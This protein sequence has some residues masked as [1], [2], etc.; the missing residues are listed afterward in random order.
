MLFFWINLDPRS[1]QR[2]TIAKHISNKNLLANST[3]KNNSRSSANKNSGQTAVSRLK[4]SINNKLGAVSVGKLNPDLDVIVINNSGSSSGDCISENGKLL[5][6]QAKAKHASQ[7]AMNNSKTNKRCNSAIPNP[8]N[9]G[10]SKKGNKMVSQSLSN[11]RIALADNDNNNRKIAPKKAD[12]S[13]EKPSVP[14]QSTVSSFNYSLPPGISISAGT[15]TNL[16]IT[17]SSLNPV[18]PRMQNRNQSLNL[19]MKPMTVQ[20]FQKSDSQNQ[21]LGSTDS[22][23]KKR[24]SLNDCIDELQK[25][26]LKLLESPHAHTNGTSESINGNANMPLSNGRSKSAGG[27]SSSHRGAIVKDTATSARVRDPELNLGS[28]V[29]NSSDAVVAVSAVFLDPHSYQLS[30]NTRT[31][32]STKGLNK[33]GLKKA[34][35]QQSKRNLITAPVSGKK[36]SNHKLKIKPL[37]KVISSTIRNTRSTAANAKIRT[38]LS[39]KPKSGGI[40]PAD[41]N[42]A[43][44]RSRSRLLRK[45]N[46]FISPNNRKSESDCSSNCTSRSNSAIRIVSGNGPNGRLEK[47]RVNK[48]PSQAFINA[49]ADLYQYRRNVMLRIPKSGVGIFPSASNVNLFNLPESPSPDSIKGVL[50]PVQDKQKIQQLSPN[51]PHA[52]HNNH[53]SAFGSSSRSSSPML[54]AGSSGTSNKIPLGSMA[55]NAAK[56][57]A[58]VKPLSPASINGALQQMAMLRRQPKWS[59]GWRFGKNKMNIHTK[60]IKSSII[61]EP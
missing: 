9:H 23:S 45:R 43:C 50:S 40:N 60:L 2:T 41:P 28:T 55:A 25:K 26:R 37:E 16:S 21:K 51:T 32:S 36:S 49:V 20:N 11:R 34:K 39:A 8:S 48:Y 22:K 14:F 61:N 29:I 54:Q 13:S 30:R 42:Q 12:K 31:A 46:Q 7:L 6:E 3:N 5:Q 10:N 44:S 33:N 35:L 1:G 24:I 4:P 53:K 15:G 59:N 57:R 38:R 52:F 19:S 18:V 58:M 17:S 56:K 47:E 27:L